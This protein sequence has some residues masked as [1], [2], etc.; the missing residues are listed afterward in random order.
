MDK[1]MRVLLT[2]GGTKVPIDRVRH[3]G[4]MS[5]GTFPSKIA[6]EMLYAA[7]YW[8]PHAHLSSS[9]L[10]ED[11]TF[12]Y[13]KD[14]RRP[15][16]LDVDIAA[17]DY[18]LKTVMQRLIALDNAWENIAGS[19]FYEETYRNFHDYELKLAQHL[20]STVA[21]PDLVIL[22]AAVADFLVQNYVDGKVR[23]NAELNIALTPAEKLIGTVK[24][25]CPACKLVGFKLMVDST[26]EQLINAAFRSVEENGCD[27]VIAND[28]RDI[29]NDDHRVHLVTADGF[30]TFETNHSD[31]NY[32]AR[33]V[34][35]NAMALVD[36]RVEAP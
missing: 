30:R 3:I 16:Q 5:R 23:S 2:S 31:P 18:D 33:V 32:L 6:F 27:L 25:K 36:E 12:L 8:H 14:S 26:D 10:I 19:R 22:A 29:Q 28:L 4:N 35:L 24:A 15:F 11:F 13:A 7:R 1:R 34:A 9:S 21:R 17:D 20:E